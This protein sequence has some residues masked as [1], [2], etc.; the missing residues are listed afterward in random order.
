MTNVR[1]RCFVCTFTFTY[2]NTK[3][4]KSL[5]CQVRNYKWKKKKFCMY[6]CNIPVLLRARINILWPA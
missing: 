6:S 2:M 5:D 1:A 4:K 3:K